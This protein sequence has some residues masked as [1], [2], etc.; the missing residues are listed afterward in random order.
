[1]QLYCMFSCQRIGVSRIHH[2]TSR[3]RPLHHRRSRARTPGARL[4]RAGPRGRR[5]RA[6]L[7][8]RD[9]RLARAS[10][11]AA[12]VLVVGHADQRAIQG[13]HDRGA[14]DRGADRLLRH[15]AVQPQQHR[16]RDLP[17][18]DPVGARG[19]GPA[20]ADDRVRPGAGLG[21]HHLGRH[22]RQLRGPLAG[23]RGALS[24][25]GCRGRGSRRV[26]RAKLRA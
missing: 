16:G 18:H 24:A 17:G 12:R 1:M 9:R 3:D 11:K 23:P 7:Q 26:A 4:L 20:R 5:A 14:D 15:D 13:P 2:W 21:P 25:G 6:D 10:R 8:P 19:R 22:H